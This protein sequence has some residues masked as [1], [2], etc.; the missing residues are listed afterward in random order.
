[1]KVCRLVTSCKKLATLYAD[2]YLYTL[3]TIDS[4]WFSW[5]RYKTRPVRES[6]IASD[7]KCLQL[8][9]YVRLPTASVW[10]E[11]SSEG[12]NLDLLQRLDRAFCDSR[13]F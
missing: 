2:V 6:G 10:H 12:A 9:E 8:D 4:S 11:L 13:L 3:N 7:T 5:A 1:M